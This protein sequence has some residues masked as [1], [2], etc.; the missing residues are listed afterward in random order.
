MKLSRQPRYAIF[1]LDGVLL[2]TEP[3]Y[4]EATAAVA[5]RF[6]KVYDWSVKRDCIGRGTLEAARIIVEA[7]AL[8]L[9]P[10]ALVHERDRLLIELVARAPAIAGAE[11][12]S[13]A[14][15]GRGVPLAIAT[16]TEAPLYAIKAARHREWLAIFGAAVCGDDPRVSRPKP[17]PDIFLAAARDLG[18]PP[19]S[20]LVFED[21]PFGVEAARAAGMQVIAL[22]DPAMD[23]ARYTHADAV[24]SGFADLTPDL[25]GF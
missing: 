2:D 19:E 18:A 10:A 12:F 14:L 8:P 4:T 5:A 23:R 7:L 13:R 17:A 1:D 6:G 24:L 15:A 11:A 21:S 22:P 20:C 9:T 25:L 16:S 3:L